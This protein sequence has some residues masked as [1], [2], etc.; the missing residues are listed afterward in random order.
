MGVVE[1]HEAT[2]AHD[3]AEEVQIDEHV[4]E[5]V[6]AID[7]RGVSDEAVP[8]VAAAIDAEPHGVILRAEVRPFPAAVIRVPSR[9]A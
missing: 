3:L 6:A 5:G 8:E 9:R 4:V 7:E 1:H 2:R